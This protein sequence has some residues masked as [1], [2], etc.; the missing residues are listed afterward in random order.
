MLDPAFVTPV[1]DRLAGR[2][3]AA[4]VRDALAEMKSGPWPTNS[5]Q[6][7][8]AAA[9]LAASFVAGLGKLHAGDLEGAA[10][11]FRAALRAAPDFTPAMMYLGACYAAGSKDR[12]AAAAWQTALLRD[13]DSPAL[14]RLAI[15]A[16]LRA[17]RP[18]SAIALIKQARARW[19]ADESFVQRQARA[20]LAEGRKREALDIVVGLEAPDE[21]LL[22]LSLATLYEAARAG[23]PV[24]T[25]ERDLQVM[26]DLRE[27][28]AKLEGPSLALVDAWLEAFKGQ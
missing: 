7:P 11:D 17:E 20:E 2:A 10:N 22:L 3:D 15:D 5:A 26:R 12:E 16:W 19:P 1:I 9:P 28:Y 23:S 25:A 21:P 24:W 27:R 14:A 18:T 8:L 4:G 13:R 6:G